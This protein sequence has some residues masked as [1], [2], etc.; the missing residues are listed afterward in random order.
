[1]PP[2]WTYRLFGTIKEC[3]EEANGEEREVDDLQGRQGQVEADRYIT[4]MS[5]LNKGIQGRTQ[6]L[7]RL[8]VG[9]YAS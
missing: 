8:G 1:M 7:N 2:L 3:L 9:R 4:T 6:D 5:R